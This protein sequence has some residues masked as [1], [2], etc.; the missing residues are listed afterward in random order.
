LVWR[1]PELDVGQNYMTRPNP[2][3]KSPTRPTRPTTAGGP[4]V[5]PPD[6]G[7]CNIYDIDDR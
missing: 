7:D 3:T 2:T 1:E 4:L 6:Y 5:G